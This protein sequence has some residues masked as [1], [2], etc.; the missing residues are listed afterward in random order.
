MGY[1]TVGARIAVLASV[2]GGNYTALQIVVIPA[3]P[4]KK[5]IQGVVMEVTGSQVTLID[6]AGKVFIM[7]LAPGVAAPSVGQFIIAT[8]QEDPVSKQLSLFAFEVSDKLLD[9]LEKNIGKIQDKKPKDEAEQ[10]DNEKQ[11]N[12]LE[13]LLNRNADRHLEVLQRV[14]DKA[15]EQAKAALS[16]VLDSA[17][18]RK[19][20]I[21]NKVEKRKGREGPPGPPTGPASNPSKPGKSGK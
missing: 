18:E 5:H 16:K 21:K 9:R 14:L 6:S 15:P 2:T 17:K 13:E 4:V 1:I 12:T 7:Q 19:D 11:M 8:V 3:Q 20:D 10:K